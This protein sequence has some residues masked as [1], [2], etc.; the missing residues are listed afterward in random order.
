MEDWCKN[1][2]IK[3]SEDQIIAENYIR[4]R[5]YKP[6]VDYGYDNVIVRADALFELE[7]EKAMEVG[8]LN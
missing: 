5:G 6:F 4:S 1:H 7:C 8:L 2:G 3:F